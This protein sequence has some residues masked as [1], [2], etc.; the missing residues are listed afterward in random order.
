MSDNSESSNDDNE[1]PDLTLSPI[2]ENSM[3]QSKVEQ[4]AKT[5]KFQNSLKEIEDLLKNKL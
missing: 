4:M 3:D 5:R 1:V 2:K